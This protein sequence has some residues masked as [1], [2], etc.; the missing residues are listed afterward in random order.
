MQTRQIACLDTAGCDDPAPITSRSCQG[1]SCAWQIGPWGDCTGSC[2]SGG[3][4]HRAVGCPLH[5]ACS[6]PTPISSRNCTLPNCRQSSTL[7]RTTS[8]QSDESVATTTTSKTSTT[9]LIP[10][11]QAPPG[12]Q[13]F[14]WF[15]GQWSTCSGACGTTE[16]RQREV[17]CVRTCTIYR[18]PRVA[19]FRCTT[20]RPDSAEDC[21]TMAAPCPSTTT[22]TSTTMPSTTLASST[23]TTTLTEREAPMVNWECI[24]SVSQGSLADCVQSATQ[25]GTDCPCCRQTTVTTALSSPVAAGAT[26]FTLLNVDGVRA[27]MRVVIS[28]RANSEVKD[29][30]EV[31]RNRRLSGK[32]RR[33]AP[34]TITIDSPLQFSYATGA[35]V[36]A[37]R[38]VVQPVPRWLLR[39]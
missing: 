10:S 28:D 27:G 25:C 18:C 12:V 33:L 4:Q 36:T 16:Q 13:A 6:E 3:L 20:A 5:A 11:Q 24:F 8:Q 22:D 2:G 38:A 9:T 34:G 23:S 19:D 29:V 1:N 30:I 32:S 37:T 31:T 39:P 26:S 21:G 35:A 15:V 7:R 17:Y 14:S